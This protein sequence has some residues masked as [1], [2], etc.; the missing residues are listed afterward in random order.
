MERRENKEG[1][2]SA[3]L[4]AHALLASRRRGRVREGGRQGQGGGAAPASRQRWGVR[5][6]VEKTQRGQIHGG[7][8]GW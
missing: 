3:D 6:A 1:R 4:P 8:E 7:G 5:S 2:E